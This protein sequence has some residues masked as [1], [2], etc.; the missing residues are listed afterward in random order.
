MSERDDRDSDPTNRELAAAFAEIVAGWND[1]APERIPHRPVTG[2][3][4]SPATET[5]AEPE[6]APEPVPYV[7][8]RDWA[9]EPEV[10]GFEPPEPG[11]WPQLSP[12]TWL[13][14]LG[15]LGAPVFLVIANWQGLSRIW[16]FL[17]VLAFIG[18]FA[19]LVNKLPRSRDGDDDGA[20]V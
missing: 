13:A 12:L 15:L 8:P 20:V 18:S 3:D 16:S 5:I 7:G 17:G 14:W 19:F 11:P 6:I 4:P 9:P 1:P 10:S 2:D